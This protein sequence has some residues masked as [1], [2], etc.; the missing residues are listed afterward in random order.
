MGE[1]LMGENLI[2]SSSYYETLNVIEALDN[3]SERWAKIISETSDEDVKMDYEED[4]YVLNQFILKFKKEAQ[5]IFGDNIV[6]L[7]HA[8]K[9]VSLLQAI[10]EQGFSL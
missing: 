8:P 7:A 4:L 6:K 10:E 3:E 5:K 2:I 9:G 1:N